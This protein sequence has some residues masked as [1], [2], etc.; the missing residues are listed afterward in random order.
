MMK[1][2]EHQ[3]ETTI[4]PASRFS[5]N[6]NELWQYRELF[7]FFTLRDIKVK[8]KQ[9]VLGVFWVML[10]PM[11]LM[12]VF[13]FFFGS[14]LGVSSEGIPYPVFAFSGLLL[15][16]FFSASISSAGNSMVQNAGIIKKIY[17]PRLIIPISSIL[18]SWIDLLVGMVLFIGFLFVYP[19][20]VNIPELLFCWPAAF[21]LSIAS[22]LGLGCWLSALMVK[23][24][25]FRFVVSFAIQIAFFLTP[26]V[27]PVSR[28]N[29]PSLK[30]ILSINPMYGAITLFRQPM[31]EGEADILLIGIS[32]S[33]ALLMIVFGIMYF[34]RTELYFADLA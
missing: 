13:T 16:N 8:Y 7:Y 25:D 18:A 4:E 28:V 22:A 10:Q 14:M 11:L 24:R 1:G 20:S 31:M 33:S 3:V 15:W 21:I 2:I 30:Y 19:V 5:I 12:M 6:F 34:K 17:F 9:T 27:Y 32:V 26:I 29:I 23:Y